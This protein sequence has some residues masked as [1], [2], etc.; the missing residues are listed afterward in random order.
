MKKMLWCA[1][2]CLIGNIT[3]QE[4]EFKNQNNVILKDWFGWLMYDM[5]RTHE[6]KPD[7]IMKDNKIILKDS[8]IVAARL[9][10]I[11]PNNTQ[12][13]KTAQN[14][15]IEL[16][17]SS[18]N[19]YEISIGNNA[20]NFLNNKIILNKMK[21]LEKGEFE[22]QNPLEESSQITVHGTPKNITQNSLSKG[23]ILQIKDS[24]IKNAYQISTTNGYF[25]DIENNEILIQD[26]KIAP[27]KNKNQTVNIS[28]V[29]IDKFKPGYT[30]EF[31][32]NLKNN[33]IKIENS[34]LYGVEN[35]SMIIMHGDLENIAFPIGKQTNNKIEIKNSKIE[36]SKNK[37]NY[38][39][40]IATG[41]KTLFEKDIF[42]NGDPNTSISK[43]GSNNEI[44]IIDSVIKEKD[45]VKDQKTTI[46]SDKIF[47]SNSG[48]GKFG[49]TRVAGDINTELLETSGQNITVR[50]IDHVQ[51]INFHLAANEIT[52][53]GKTF[54]Q[55][56]GKAPILN[57]QDKVKID[58]KEVEL[59][60]HGNPNFGK[61]P[62]FDLIKNAEGNK[63]KSFKISAGIASAYDSN[64]FTE[65]NENNTYFV[66]LKG[67]NPQG[68]KPS[69]PQPQ[70]NSKK[71]D[72]FA[73]VQSTNLLQILQTNDGINN[74]ILDQNS[75]LN[76]FAYVDN[77][78]TKYKNYK[79]NLKGQTY[80]AG[81]AL[82]NENFATGFFTQYSSGKFDEKFNQYL[83][84]TKE[85]LY[86]IGILSKI[87]LD[88]FYL[89]GFAKIGQ[90][91]SKNSFD[92]NSYQIADKSKQLF[93]SV[94][95]F[96]GHD[97]QIS[98]KIS[99]DNKIGFSHTWLESAKIKNK[100]DVLNLDSISSNKAEIQNSIKAQFDK[101]FMFAKT[102][103]EYE[104]LA[105]ST[106][107][108]Y[109]SKYT[110]DDFKGFSYGGK[111]GVGK[112]IANSLVTLEANFLDGKRKEMGAQVGFIYNF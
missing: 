110:K 61:D 88:N 45:D 22:K 81:I 68:N 78:V 97:T 7:K 91:E 3:A 29:V 112:N 64:N 37:G 100:N 111:I 14:N 6:L 40:I 43:T 36:F 55:T 5:Y 23:N 90:L 11:Q 39:K 99:F 71:G 103:F 8:N 73:S 57:T 93:Y 44:N 42:A 9:R 35:I 109:K 62:K 96:A 65:G 60:I 107:N 26:S 56:N 75:S 15:T 28:T 30:K 13:V 19:G 38:E 95:I 54:Y 51:K 70:I 106:I 98:E 25:G 18:L 46:F 92:L 85:K 94:G 83:I 108:E 20:N 27:L 74:K 12:D 63:A 2:I 10:I 82:N 53:N 41:S 84:N 52:E 4:K 1:L 21:L 34:E 76:I 86:D 33:K 80:T 87:N 69:K 59:H 89:D 50:N 101:F 104:F 58:R 47:L 67:E 66:K 32:P 105:N 102:R 31:I 48:M 17:N 79:N 77:F 16:I 72:V 24:D 49:N